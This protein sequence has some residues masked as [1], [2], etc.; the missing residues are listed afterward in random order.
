MLGIDSCSALSFGI[1]GIECA[2]TCQTGTSKEHTGE[3]E[4]DD[5]EDQNANDGYESVRDG[6]PIHHNA[7]GW[8]WWYATINFVMREL[9][10]VSGSL[11]VRIRCNSLLE[12]ALSIA[13][14]LLLIEGSHA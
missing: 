11:E 4:K 3:Q 12:G 6:A 7:T 2:S 8:S 13:K 5:Q 1:L 14:V 9:L 10:E